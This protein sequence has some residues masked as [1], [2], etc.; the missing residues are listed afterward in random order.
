MVRVAHFRGTVLARREGEPLLSWVRELTG[1]S[2]NK[3]REL[4][5]QGKVYLDGKPALVPFDTVA[6][7][8]KV[9]ID[10]NRR[11]VRALPEFDESRILHR[12]ATLIIVD[13]PPSMASVPPTR[14]G[15]PTLLD[16]LVRV[17]KPQRPTPLHRLDAE[18]S[19]LMVFGV[20]GGDLEP[21][22]RGFRRHEIDRRYYAV[23]LGDPV[24]GVLEDDIDVTRE[25]FGGEPNIRHAVTQVL[26]LTR[27]A[28]Y[29][30]VECRPQ[31]GRWHQLRI[32]LSLHG[33]PIVGEK[34]HLP[35]TL[36]VPWGRRQRLAL[37]S[38][39][40][41]LKHPTTRQPLQWSTPIPERMKR[42]LQQDT[43]R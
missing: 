16:H 3:A 38:F 2:Q 31:T 20:E 32:Q 37:H 39:Y 12:D 1:W 28:P 42:L 27:R 10:T 23:V 19:G 40:L 36:E 43:D 24:S 14:T 5:R 8:A 41:A 29:T 7:G 21:I 13:K 26:V 30:L 9:S 6:A 34:E 11:S 18:T 35:P 4:V 25:R 33:T 22:R 15:E 17:M